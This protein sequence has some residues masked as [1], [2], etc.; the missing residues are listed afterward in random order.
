MAALELLWLLAVHLVLTALPAALAVFVA[1]RRGLRDV[2]LVL[3][4]ALAPAGAAAM[5]GVWAVYLDPQLG[6]FGEFAGG[7]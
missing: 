3:C 7:G 1:A 2:P 5:L 6:Q 4:V